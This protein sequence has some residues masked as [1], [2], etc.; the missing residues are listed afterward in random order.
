MQHNFHLTLALDNLL[1]Y[2]EVAQATWRGHM[3]AFLL[4]APAEVPAARHMHEAAF[5]RTPAQLKSETNLVPD[6]RK[7]TIKQIVQYTWS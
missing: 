6:L 3:K 7:L 5:A 2:C 1:P 4:M